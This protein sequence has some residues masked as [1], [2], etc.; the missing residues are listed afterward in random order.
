MTTSTP[1]TSAAGSGKRPVPID[2]AAIVVVAF[3]AL[4]G[5]LQRT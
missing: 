4:V 5:A 2:R 1:D 3:F